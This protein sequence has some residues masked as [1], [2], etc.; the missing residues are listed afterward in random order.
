MFD[1]EFTALPYLKGSQEPP[2][3]PH[4]LQHA[5]ERA[6][7]N[8]EQLSHDWLHPSSNVEDNKVGAGEITLLDTIN[9][10]EDNNNQ[11]G[12]GT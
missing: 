1:N 3:W 4:F 7:Y 6:T 8:Q 10:T 2:N 12:D 11:V 5:N 9:I